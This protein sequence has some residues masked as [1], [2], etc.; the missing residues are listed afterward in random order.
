MSIDDIPVGIK[1]NI[2][3]PEFQDNQP[4]TTVNDILENRLQHKSWEVRAH[5]F[6]E[7]GAIL[8]NEEP[9]QST[10]FLVSLWPTYLENAN[11]KNLKKQLM[12]SNIHIQRK[13]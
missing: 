4:S 8:T 7:L 2:I 1:S 6:E 10:L 12:H 11:S 13:I 3:I 9:Q 5:A